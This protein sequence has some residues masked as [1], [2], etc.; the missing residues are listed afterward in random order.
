MKKLLLSTLLLSF[1]IS[2]SQVVMTKTDSIAFDRFFINCDTSFV[3]PIDTLDNCLLLV[4][5]KDKPKKVFYMKACIV[6][7]RGSYMVIEYLDKKRCKL[8][9]NIVVWNHN[10][11]WE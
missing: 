7:Y 11:G 9:E 6:V 3:A 10:F 2:N 5:E 1:L 4:S 8:P